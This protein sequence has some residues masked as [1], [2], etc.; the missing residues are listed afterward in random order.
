[1][2]ITAK[3][4][5]RAQ[6]VQQGFAIVVGARALTDLESEAAGV[7]SGLELVERVA[8]TTIVQSN[9][10]A[11]DGAGNLH[12]VLLQASPAAFVIGRAYGPRLRVTGNNGTVVNLRLEEGI[13]VGP[14]LGNR[15]IGLR[16]RAGG[17]GQPAQAAPRA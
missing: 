11:A 3:N 17:G 10:L 7:R 12:A 14:V 9:A 16:L 6:G 1:M 2:F 13:A 4:A 8:S 15:A 5:L